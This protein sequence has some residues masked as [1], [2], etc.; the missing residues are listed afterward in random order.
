MSRHARPVALND[1]QQTM[2][3]RFSRL[4][5]LERRLAE[6]VDIVLG[7]A[8][9]RTSV[10]LAKALGVDEQ[11]VT[12]WRLRF[13]AARERLWAASEPSISD[14]HLEAVLLDVLGDEERSGV[15]PKFSAEQ[16]TN[17]I[18][19]AC[20]NPQELGLPV[21]HWTP[22]ELALEAV[23]QGIVESISTRHIGRF[24]E[25][26]DLKPHRSQYWLNPKIDD[27]VRHAEQV[28]QICEL[29]AQA[30]A[31]HEQGVHVVSTDEKTSI[32]ALER[33]KP[34]LPMLPGEVE[35]REF[36][37]KR[38]GTLCLTAN[39]E[40][41]TGQV[42]APTVEVN[43]TEAD[44]ARHIEQTVNTAPGDKWIFVTDSLNTHLSETLVLNIAAR[45]NL[46]VDLGVKGKAGIL[47]DMETRREFLCDP[48]HQ[49]SF[50]YTPKHC[51][52]MNQV[53][54]WFSILSRRALKRASFS[55]LDEL[56]TRL[57]EFIAY[58][59]RVLAKPFRWTYTGRPLAA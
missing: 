8:Q 11:R 47:A 38:H 12:R 3:E 6:R 41:A 20:K 36:E 54:I 53:E 9:G 13:A 51:S 31:L 16:L 48:S 42:I 34:T 4:R 14:E 18:A 50:I 43:R 30:P 27:P 17:I 52:W 57:L 33:C 28:K 56:K 1:R 29:Y 25:E 21:T 2:L 46:V 45:E 19:L 44:F 15:P 23:R 35:K 22:K 39:L 37:Y 58:F 24:L 49:V 10:S 32:Q 59:N 5:T 40:V 26:A 55:S 7:A